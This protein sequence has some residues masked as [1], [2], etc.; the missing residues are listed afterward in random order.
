[1]ESEHGSGV[2]IIGAIKKIAFGNKNVFGGM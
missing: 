2:A 1:M